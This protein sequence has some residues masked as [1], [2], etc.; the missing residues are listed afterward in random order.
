MTFSYWAIPAAITVWL[1][2]W[3]YLGYRFGDST[4]MFLRAVGAV[5]LSLSC[6]LIWWLMDGV[7]YFPPS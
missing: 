5:L 7:R 4:V 2:G 1:L 3:V 6:W